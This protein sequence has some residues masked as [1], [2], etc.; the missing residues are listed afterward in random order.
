MPQRKD[1]IT[2]EDYT[3]QMSRI[4]TSP[5]DDSPGD[6]EADAGAEFA[7]GLNFEARVVRDENDF[8]EGPGEEF[9]QES[10]INVQPQVLTRPPV[11][12]PES[13]KVISSEQPAPWKDLE[14]PADTN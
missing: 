8:A 2:E 3:I 11:D 6:S 5:E 13:A 9:L 12:L 1:F 7:M 14:H 10:Q 4:S